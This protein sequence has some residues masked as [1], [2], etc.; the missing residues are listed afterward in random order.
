MN[1]HVQYTKICKKFIFI[2]T[3]WSNDIKVA[4]KASFGLV[5]LINSEIDLE[6]KL[7]KFEKSFERQELLYED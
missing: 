4:Y 1:V 3:N 6:K 5:E 2:N 7:N